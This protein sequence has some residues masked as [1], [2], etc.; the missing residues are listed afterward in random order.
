MIVRRLLVEHVII[1]AVRKQISSAEHIRYV[2]KRVEE[3]VRK[4]YAHVPETMQL[5]ETE[6]VAEERCLTNFVDFIGEGRGSHALAKA[7]VETERRVE[8]LRDEIDGLR[9]SGDKV[10]QSP[11]VEWIEERLEQLGEVLKRRTG[12]SAMILRG[13]LGQIRL[14]PTRGEIGRAYF[15]ARTSIDILA[16][17]GKLE[18][19]KNKNRP[20]GGSS[21]LQWWRRWESNP[22]PRNFSRRLLRV[23]LAV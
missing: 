21:S 1:E 15:V 20:E 18:K 22:R 23:Q 12:P 10:F 19:P 6:L 17:L 8:V 2:L 16:V 3:E 5:K 7:L 14:V 9:R 4:L 13:L 11:P